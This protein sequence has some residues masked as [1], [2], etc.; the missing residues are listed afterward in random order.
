MVSICTLFLMLQLQSIFV[1]LCTTCMIY[2][3]VVMLFQGEGNISE[4][5]NFHVILNFNSTPPSPFLYSPPPL[6]LLLHYL[7]HPNTDKLTGSFHSLGISLDA[8]LFFNSNSLYFLVYT[9]PQSASHV[10]YPLQNDCIQGRFVFLL[11]RN[12][13]FDLWLNLNHLNIKLD[14]QMKIDVHGCYAKHA[15]SKSGG[16]YLFARPSENRNRESSKEMAILF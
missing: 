15:C 10:F 2:T 4:H 1:F 13:K 12:P 16:F 11:K 9:F 14:H 3:L 7:T 6:F 5:I 8:V